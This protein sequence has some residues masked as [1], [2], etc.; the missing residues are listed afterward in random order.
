MPRVA[1]ELNVV[2]VDL[3]PGL[4]RLE[5]RGNMD[6]TRVHLLKEALD[7][8]F[9]RQIFK[10]VVDLRGAKYLSSSG[11]ACFITSLD[12]AIDHGGR[13]A[14]IAADKQVQRIA[15][16]LMLADVFTFAADEAS[17]VEY[18]NRRK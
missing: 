6:P 8:L 14:F 13:F 5:L 9:S 17:A 15:Q 16:I 10:V 7:G 2:A 12:T 1:E 4:A 18:L 11:I 3:A